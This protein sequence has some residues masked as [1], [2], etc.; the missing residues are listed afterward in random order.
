VEEVALTT[1][2]HPE[3]AGALFFYE[4]CDGLKLVAK[5]LDKDI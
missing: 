2:N 5:T 1:T 4:F 3:S